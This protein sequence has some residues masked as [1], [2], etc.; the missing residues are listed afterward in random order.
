MVAGQIGMRISSS[1]DKTLSLDGLQDT[2][3]PV[4]GWWMFTKKLQGG[5][6]KDKL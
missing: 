2:V 1:G 5:S 6:S 3:A 4:A